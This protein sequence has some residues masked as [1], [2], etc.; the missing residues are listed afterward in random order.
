MQFLLLS[1]SLLLPAM[2]STR[3]DIEI[4]CHMPVELILSFWCEIRKTYHTSV[5]KL[6][7]YKRKKQVSR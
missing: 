5:D 2:R 7:A 6:R 1:S 4:P 3:S